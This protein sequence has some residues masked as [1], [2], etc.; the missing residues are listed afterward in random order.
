[1]TNEQVRIARAVAD[2]LREA[3][4]VLYDAVTFGDA[5]DACVRALKLVR[6]ALHGEETRAPHAFL[7]DFSRRLGAR[8]TIDP[9]T[10]EDR[11]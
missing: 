4:D 9:P 5:H 10:P 1:M 6:L 2:V 3:E 7:R 11:A 8:P